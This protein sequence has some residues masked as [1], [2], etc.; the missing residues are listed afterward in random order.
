MPRK[1]RVI[2]QFGQNP[3]FE[4]CTIARAFGSGVPRRQGVPH[5]RQF[6]VM[7]INGVELTAAALSV[8]DWR[9]D[10]LFTS[11]CSAWL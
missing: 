2:M 8:F 1:K 10:I 5:R 4:A 11:G 7:P 6:D 9:F 3:A